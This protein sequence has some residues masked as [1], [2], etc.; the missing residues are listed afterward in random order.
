MAR[1]II[2]GVI[3]MKKILLVSSSGGHFEQLKILKKLS[4]NADFDILV[5]TEK[6]KYT[7]KSEADFFVGQ[8]NRKEIFFIIIYDL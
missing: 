3:K 1:F 7:K 8:M 4:E 2:I 5:V 6:T